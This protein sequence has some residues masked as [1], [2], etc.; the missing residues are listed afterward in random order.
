[1]PVSS[2]V[3][4]PSDGLSSVVQR[5]HQSCVAE[6]AGS[7]RSPAN[8]SCASLR[9]YAQSISLPMAAKKVKVGE[10]EI[11]AG[12]PLAVIAGPCVIESRESA[13]RH[14]SALKEAADRV[15]FHYIFKSSY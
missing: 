14:A 2:R 15:G 12:A 6:P 9:V 13:L 1:M 3:Q 7:Q 8:Q 10:V 5:I 11:G 4:I